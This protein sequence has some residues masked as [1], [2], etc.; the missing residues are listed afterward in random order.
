VVAIIYPSRLSQ[1]REFDPNQKV[2]A[3][4]I[5]RGLRAQMRTGNILTGQN[6][7]AL[8]F[9]PK[10]KPAQLKIDKGLAEIPTTPTELSNLQA[11]VSKIADK[12][13]KFPL[14][15][16]GQDLRKTM[17]TMNTAIDSTNKLVKQMDGK[18]APAMQATLDDARK[19]MQ[20]TQS[21]LASDAPLQQDVRRAMQQMTRAAA[22][23]QLMSDYI[24]Q[25]P[26]SLIR[27]KAANQDKD[28]DKNKP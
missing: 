9:F 25:H 4:F 20:S 28:Q 7:I 11:Q 22:S 13:A 6:Y 2:L 8:D 10:A 5:Q 21:V 15:E 27:G 3:E 24:E 17:A 23:L 12:L 1:G 16:I 18:V 14:N 19:T 26:E